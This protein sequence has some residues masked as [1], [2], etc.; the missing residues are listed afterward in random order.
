MYETIAYAWD[1][2]LCE[3]VRDVKTKHVS[4]LQNAGN[5][6]TLCLYYMFFFNKH[7]VYKHT[8]AQISNK[9]SII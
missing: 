7:N 2:Y 6:A 8:V 3:D 9:L 4:L 5:L 1:N